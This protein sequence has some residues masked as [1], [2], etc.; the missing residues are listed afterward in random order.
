[1]P[2]LPLIFE[3]PKAKVVEIVLS[4]PKI[5]T[6]LRPLLITEESEERPAVT[7]CVERPE[8]VVDKDERPRGV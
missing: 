5:D 6:V 1:M 8:R 2:S 3:R 4:E 7:D